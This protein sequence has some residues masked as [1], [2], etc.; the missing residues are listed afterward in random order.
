MARPS[1]TLSSMVVWLAGFMVPRRRRAEWRREWRGELWHRRSRAAESNQL[2]VRVRA[3]LL[4]RSLGSI[5]H[6]LW[7]RGRD[8][9]HDVLKQDCRYA[10]RTLFKTPGFTAVAIITIALGI[11][12]NTAVFSLV[13]ALLLQP[14][15]YAEPDR[16]VRLRALELDSNIDGN[17]S[18]PDYVDVSKSRSFDDLALVDREPYNLGGGN[19][20]VYVQGAQVSATLFEVLGTTP[21]LGRTF[22]PEEEGPDAPNVVVLGERLWRASFAADELLVGKDVTIDAEPFTVIGVVPVGAGFPDEA[23]LWVP[24]RFDPDAQGRSSRWANVIGRLADGVTLEQ[25]SDEVSAL[26]STLAQEYPGSNSGIGILLVGLR[27]SRTGDDLWASMA[28]MLGAVGF[29]LLI[30]CANL[31]N[32]MLVRG[33]TR[34]REI[35]VRAAMGASRLRIVRQLITES[36]LLASAGTVLGFAL[37]IWAIDFLFSAAIPVAVPEWIDFSADWRVVA[38]TAAAS[39]FAVF[40]FGLAPALRATTTNLHDAL[41][42]ASGHG[43]A[44]RAKQRTR[45]VLV[46]AEVALSIILLVGAGLMIQSFIGM[47]SIEPGYDLDNSFMLTTAYADVNYSEAEQRLAFYREARERLLAFPGVEAVG[48]ITQPPLR[49][50]WNITPIDVEGLDRGP[51]ESSQ[52]FLHVVTPGYIDAAGVSLVRGRDLSDLD[53]SVDAPEAAL[54]NQAFAE[55][56]WPGV[57]PI[58]KRIRFTYMDDDTWIYVV[59]VVENTKHRELVDNVAAEMYYPY[60]RY[61]AFYSRMTWMVRTAP[62]PIGLIA[63]AQNEIRSLDSNQAVYDVMTLRS[64]VDESLWGERFVITLFWIFGAIALLLSTVGLYGS[65]AYS[66]AQ[67]THE[68]GIRMAM[69]A[70]ARDVLGMVLKRGM[71][72]STIGGA[73][74]LAGSFALAQ[75]LAG[76][77][78]EVNPSEPTVYVAVAVLLGLVS[79]VAGFFSAVRATRVDPLIALRDE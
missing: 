25:A 63:A 73:I 65:V 21:L 27:E 12:T 48:G 71:V 22:R 13:N 77:L 79:L 24:I 31:A 14:Y 18:Y 55:E 30:A 41:K 66:A 15:P 70:E 33:A 69:G 37:G 20:T 45:S 50:G 6:A 32:L 59:G 62:D 35:A 78:Y 44:G 28:L 75:L 67:R 54:V 34:E 53:G 8:W 26:A 60:E 7:L 38:F 49:G 4:R 68:I 40:L 3:N 36:V 29:V 42:E 11:G 43:T 47:S 19:E 64:A 51:D 56:H 39:V 9:K 23:G 72:L 1:Y 76:S 10:I 46:V 58:G 61:A 57:D 52:T 5:R 17:M 74:G 2:G 16:L